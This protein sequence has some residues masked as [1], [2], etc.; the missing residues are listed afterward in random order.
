MWPAS[1][2]KPNGE[3]VSIAETWRPPRVTTNNFIDN[4]FANLRYRPSRVSQPGQSPED[5]RVSNRPPILLVLN[6]RG[7][8]NCLGRPTPE[9]SL[10]CLALDSTELS[11]SP[12]S[13]SHDFDLRIR[14]PEDLVIE[15]RQ[16]PPR[17]FCTERTFASHSEHVDAPN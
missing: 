1:A 7:A 12:G 2:F 17:F 14:A 11:P 3:I 9:A 10:K 13:E 15:S 8:E 6:G 4:C 16:C 5:G